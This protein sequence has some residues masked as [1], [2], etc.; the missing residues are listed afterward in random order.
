MEIL[1]SSVGLSLAIILLTFVLAFLFNRFFFRLVER[2]SLILKNDPA[3]YKFLRHLLVGMIYLICFGFAIFVIPEL[4]TFASSL[5]AGAGILAVA[6]GFAS[7]HAL[8]NLISGLFIIIFK[9]FRI[10][11]RLNLR[12]FAGIVEDITL[13]HTIIRDFENKRII[14]PNAV[15]SNEI[16]I[17]AD[18]AEERICRWVD[19]QISY[20]SNLTLAKQIMAEEVEKHP[21]HVDPRS[22]EEVEAGAPIARVRVMALTESGVSLRAWSWAQSAADAFVLGCDLLESIKL[23]FD[24]EGVE[25]PYPHRTVTWK[26]KGSDHRTEQPAQNTSSQPL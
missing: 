15:I 16:L 23:R 20:E 10:N 24:A 13:R 2:S 7:Q 18:F 22:P 11:D 8:S 3:D 6:V 4:R 25:I 14:I 12:T 9:P 19:L 21:L 5:L 26:E 17:N 1:T